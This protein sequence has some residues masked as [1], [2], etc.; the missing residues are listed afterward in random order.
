LVPRNQPMRCFAM[1]VDHLPNGDLDTH[2]LERFLD[3]AIGPNQWLT[4]EW[5]F[6]DP[7][8]QEEHGLTVPVLVPE[9]VA[10]RLVLTDLEGPL[11][12]IVSDHPV[13]GVDARRWRWAAFAA[14]PNTH[15]EGRFP[16]EVVNA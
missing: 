1:R 7:P 15:G 9:E 13:V 14:R 4:T 2:G 3:A 6:A 8:D 5:L 11:Q 12:R 10:T 16:W